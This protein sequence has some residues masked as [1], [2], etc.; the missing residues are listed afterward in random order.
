MHGPAHVK[1]SKYLI[2]IQI[3]F[4]SP[5]INRGHSGCNAIF[6]QVNNQS[7]RNALVFLRD[8][9][10]S[11]SEPNSMWCWWCH[12]DVRW[13]WLSVSAARVWLTRA[14]FWRPHSYNGIW[15][16][17]FFTLWAFSGYEND[18]NVCD[19][20]HR[21]WIVKTKDAVDK[22]YRQT[23]SS[24]LNFQEFKVK[25]AVEISKKFRY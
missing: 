20:L 14:S 4:F 3:L 19:F 6:W 9:Q 2:W 8:F 23:M 1:F 5:V 24:Q 12:G 21:E 18:E 15:L 11:S 22:S 25:I 7:V 10:P 17:E 13:T 16:T